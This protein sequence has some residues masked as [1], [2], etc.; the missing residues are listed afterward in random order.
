MLVGEVLVANGHAEVAEEWLTE[1]LDVVLR[2]QDELESKPSDPA[3]DHV[4]MVSFEV[5]Q[6]RHGVRHELGLPHDE[7]DDLADELMEELE[8]SLDDG[9]VV[10]F[11]PQPE[12][13]EALRSW[14]D[15]AADHG[16][17]WDEHRATTEQELRMRAEHSAG[18]LGVIPGTAD[19]LAEFARTAGSEQINAA[20]IQAHRDSLV[21]SGIAPIPW[22]PGRN[23]PCW[24]GSESKYK[25]CCL[26]RV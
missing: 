22:P 2:R 15:L 12:Y 10:L 6:A 9:A 1:A 21:D 25:K 8:D 3:Y 13:D 20:T 26:P 24:C 4:A 5:L 16:A 18:G 14:P 11:L 7:Y 19:A 17:T 23:D